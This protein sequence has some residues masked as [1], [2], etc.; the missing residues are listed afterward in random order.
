[1][2][3]LAYGLIGAYFCILLKEV[4]NREGFTVNSGMQQMS[5]D[6]V[7]TRIS[8]NADDFDLAV[9]LNDGNGKVD[10]QTLYQYF[11][12]NALYNAKF[13]ESYTIPLRPCNSSN[14]QG[15]PYF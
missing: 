2:T 15:V 4:I 6:D 10:Q 8:M 11:S 9:R 7:S 3:L 1:M 13:G 14:F 12:I 5:F